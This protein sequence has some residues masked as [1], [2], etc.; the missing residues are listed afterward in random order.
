MRILARTLMLFMTFLQSSIDFLSVFSQRNSPTVL[1][2]LS[3]WQ[4]SP[5]SSLLNLPSRSRKE[6]EQP[7]LAFAVTRA[8][9]F[10]DDGTNFTSCT[11]LQAF[12]CFQMCLLSMWALQK[13]QNVVYL[14]DCFLSLRISTF[15]LATNLF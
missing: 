14:L 5:F 1:M 2:T 9:G 6:S 7:L 15:L 8:S 4:I 10:T 13:L 11:S 12:K 3:E